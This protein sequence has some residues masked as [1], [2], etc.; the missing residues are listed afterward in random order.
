MVEI[1]PSD[2]S[3]CPLHEWM[4]QRRIWNRFDLINVQYPQSGLPTVMLENRIVIGADPDR[5]RSTSQYLVQQSACDDSVDVA[6]MSAKPTILRVWISTA[7]MT[8]WDLRCR[9]AGPNDSQ[10]NRSIGPAPR[11]HK[12]FFACPRVVSQDGPELPGSGL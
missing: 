3:D 6:S 8:Q 5:W 1:F 9:N 12:L 10:R 7:S 11:L 4:R 2:G